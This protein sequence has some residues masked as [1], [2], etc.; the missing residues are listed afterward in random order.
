MR[1][2]IFFSI[3]ELF[4]NSGHKQ[5]G[6]FSRDVAKSRNKELKELF[7]QGFGIHHAGMLRSDRTMTERLFSEGL[8]KVY[9]LFGIVNFVNCK[10]P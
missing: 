6:L 1:S 5:Y 4:D 9:L 10:D 3:L 8:V 2:Y 7:A